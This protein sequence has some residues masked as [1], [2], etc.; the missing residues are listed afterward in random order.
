MSAEDELF[1]GLSSDRL[2]RRCR[3]AGVVLALSFAIPY[4]HVD[5]VPQFLWQILG[6]LPPAA[7]VAAF[8]TA[9]AGIAILLAS[10]K[11]RRAST[12][13]LIVVASLAAAWLLERLGAD[14][15]AWDVL[16]LPE[17]LPGRPLSMLVGL[18]AVGA[19]M[20]LAFKP[21]ARRAARIVLGLAILSIAGFYLWPA[22]GEA[23]IT[24]IVRILLELPLLPGFRFVLGAGLMLL[25]ISFP[26]FVAVLGLFT[27]LSPPSNE[28]RVISRL[29]TFGLPGLLGFFVFRSLLLSFGDSSLPAT[30]GGVALLAA[31]LGLLAAAIE[32][33]VEVSVL[34]G[35][36]PG[37]AAA[38]GRPALPKLVRAAAGASGALLV[39]GAAQWW[40]ARP[41]PKG[42]DWKLRAPSSDADAVFGA[43]LEDWSRIRLRWDDRVREASSAS[44]MVEL[45]AAERAVKE[46]ASP[47]DPPVRD[48]LTALLL[49]SRDLDLA[50]RRWFRLVSDLN[51]AN[52][53]SGA[54]YYV[55]P[56]VSMFQTPD[57]LRRRFGVH[58]F[59]IERV[60]AVRAGAARFATLH[61]RRLG[62][63]GGRHGLLGFSR[64]QQPFALVVLDEIEK[65]EAEL[66][67][68]AGADPPSCSGADPSLA[69]GSTAFGS[70]SA[71]F[72]ALELDK[73]MLDCGRAIANLIL[74]DRA[75]LAPALVSMT[76]RHELQHQIDGPH[77][78]LS[79]AV[80]ER[81]GGYTKNAQELV[82]R[83]L[84]AYIAELT[85]AGASPKLGLIA[86][87]RFTR[88]GP[89]SALHHIS[90]LAVEA[91]TRRELTNRFGGT[92][93]G[94]VAKSFAQLFSEDDATLRQRA[95]RAWEELY[96]EVLPEISPEG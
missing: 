54:P 76:E 96:D 41:P 78:P 20:N 37:E 35:H 55:D 62:K 72:G 25:V 2:R 82:N 47:L 87:L 63:G 81:M 1:F 64:D 31:L 92:E 15:A 26:A 22:R 19:G 58:G 6:E 65:N 83:E 66:A 70:D 7:I 4:E 52:R 51:E 60:R 68:L 13:A 89:R 71:V 91:L 3:W 43:T 28:P 94:E 74:E 10:G 57:G 90:V 27:A 38:S 17:S 40:L 32:V 86:L 95:T 14:R 75:A 29:V 44:A 8:S 49:E 30:I 85:V 53:T 5:G 18:G 39:L 11:A 69:L 24:T 21:H 93:P 79:S 42:I 48:A 67:P 56:S 33:L 12:L 84:S 46:R 16:P 80:L 88:S 50:G 34:R 45:K 59:R 77:L 36:E 23:P 73:A 61:V 9:G